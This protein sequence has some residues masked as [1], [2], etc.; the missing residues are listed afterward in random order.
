MFTT[1]HV[2]HFMRHILCV[3]CHLSHVMCHMSQV[4]CH[5]SHV[6]CH[7]FSLPFLDKMLGVSQQ[8]V[9]Y[10]QGL[11]CL[12]LLCLDFFSSF[13]DF[14]KHLI[15]EIS[16]ATSLLLMLGELAGG[17]SVA[18]TRSMWQ[19]TTRH[20]HLSVCFF[21]KCF[22]FGSN[23]F[24]Y[25]WCFFWSWCFYLHRSRDSA[26]PVCGILLFVTYL[27][28]QIHLIVQ[29]YSYLCPIPYNHIVS[30]YSKFILELSF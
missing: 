12:I 15:L 30:F 29:A 10:P 9:C 4:T 25:W 19:S 5:M 11:P 26:S 23:C 2:L 16:F 18:V 3:T 27:F 7:F 6:I 14:T 8:R 17:G 22:R 21:F 13:F 28:S 1:H 20:V 24:C